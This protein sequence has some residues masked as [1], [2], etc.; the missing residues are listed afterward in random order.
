[1][2]LGVANFITKIEG[3]KKERIQIDLGI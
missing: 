1:M 3:K 2:S